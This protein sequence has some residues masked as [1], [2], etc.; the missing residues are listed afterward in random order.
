MMFIVF[1]PPDMLDISVEPYAVEKRPDTLVQAYLL[2]P[3]PLQY[4]IMNLECSASAECLLTIM[5]PCFV[6][7]TYSGGGGSFGAEV[8]SLH[9]S[10]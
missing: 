4:L 1:F 5:R 6:I 8:K 9:L 7:H 3:V 10:S 2:F